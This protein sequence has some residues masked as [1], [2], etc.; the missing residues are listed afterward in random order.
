VTKSWICTQ[1]VKICFQN[2]EYVK[3]IVRR[4][5]IVFDHRKALYRNNVVNLLNL[6]E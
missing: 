4:P 3:E 2:I 5:H 6:Y 1:I